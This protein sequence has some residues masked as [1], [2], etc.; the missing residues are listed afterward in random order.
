[1]SVV[2][3]VL[4]G[5]G[6]FSLFWKEDAQTIV[7]ASIIVILFGGYLVFYTKTIA[8]KYGNGYDDNDYF[9]AAVS[10]FTS[11]VELAVRMITGM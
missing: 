5:I 8:G 1:M 6:A 11:I 2:G 10:V 4:I 9:M 7:Y 3:I